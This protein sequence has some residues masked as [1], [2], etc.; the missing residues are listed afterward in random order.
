MAKG[1]WW[2]KFEI[3]GWLNDPKLRR[4]KRENR[5]SWLTA[6]CMMQLEGS[7]E[8]TGTHE[9]LANLLG[10]TFTEF[11]DFLNDLVRTNVA[12]VTES[13]ADFTQPVTI[14]SRR[15]KRE[16]NTKENNRLRKQKERSHKPVTADVTTKSQDIVRSKKK[17]ER[18]E[19]EKE[20]SAPRKTASPKPPDSEW[21][22]ELSNE[23][24]YTGINIRFEFNKAQIWAKNNRR[25][26]TRRFF[27]GWLN[28]AAPNPGYTNGHGPPDGQPAS[29]PPER[30]QEELQ[31][32]F[33][34]QA[35]NRPIRKITL[36][37]A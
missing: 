12:D 13:H 28:R 14:T 9:E 30:T 15:Y 32:L 24:A 33:E 11:A 7:A 5:D 23:P 27:V 16:L 19:E 21:L 31:A 8:L 18:K 35:H 36:D 3:H 4:L 37:D 2:F 26:C 10:L 22:D 20:K 17:E 34:K 25:Q 6:C 1:D 29:K